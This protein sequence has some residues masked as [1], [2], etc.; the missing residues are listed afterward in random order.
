MKT[1]LIKVT[2]MTCGGCVNSLTR[3]LKSINGVDAVQ[4][5]LS[6]GDT[7]VQYNENLTSPEQLKSAV[8]NAGY[9]LVG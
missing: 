2:G 4:V 9:G 7:Q 6:T 5:D 8:K 3:A 1:E